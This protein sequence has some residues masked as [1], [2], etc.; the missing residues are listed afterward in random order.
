MTP[1]TGLQRL[2]APSPLPPGGALLAACGEMM[3]INLPERRDRRAEFERQ[4]RTIGLSLGHP[5]VRLCAAIRPPDA[6][7][8]P[9]IG[10]HGCFM[11]HLSVLRQARDDGKARIMICEDD[12][13]FSRSLSRRASLLAT[14][15]S[16]Q[17]W[18]IFYGFTNG[19]VRGTQLRPG[20]QLV[21]LAPD[22]RFECSHIMAFSGRAIARLV[23]Y[24][25]AM[26]ARRG[27]DPDGGPMHVDGAYAW[28]RHAHPQLT[29][30]AAH[31][32][33]GYQRASLTNVSHPGAKDRTP[34][35]RSVAAL[36][37]KVKNLVTA[38]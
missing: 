34:G 4:L 33:M 36:A 6:G 30:I 12:L 38:R 28:F 20:G 11:S 16:E 24:L 21:R 13:N 5:Q 9:S 29:A 17:P 27:G 15:L 1:L 7:D 19:G 2:E 37:R 35:V 23:P 26:L 22:Q 31:P 18:D 3:V 25:E 14:E 10:A 32:D 8:F